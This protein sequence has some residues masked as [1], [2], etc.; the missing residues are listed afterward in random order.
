MRVN[1]LGG[2]GGDGL[3]VRESAGCRPDPTR[4][5]GAT[6]ALGDGRTASI[7][8]ARDARRL[9]PRP[10]M[11]DVFLVTSTNEQQT[12]SPV[13]RRNKTPRH[14]GRHRVGLASG[15]RGHWTPRGFFADKPDKNTMIRLILVNWL[16]RLRFTGL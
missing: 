6:A 9:P 16:A 3:C 14:A 7:A 15:T 11:R 4:R 5:R 1:F 13:A 2:C 10:A 12:P 8:A